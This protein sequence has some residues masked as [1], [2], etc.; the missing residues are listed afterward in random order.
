MCACVVVRRALQSTTVRALVT[1]TQQSGRA[2]ACP[3]SRAATNMAC[4]RTALGRPHT[5]SDANTPG[6]QS[7]NKHQN[8]CVGARLC[9]CVANNRPR[10]LMAA[11]RSPHPHWC[12][13]MA[14]TH[15]RHPR[16]AHRLSERT[17]CECKA[18]QG[19]AHKHWQ[20]AAA[21]QAAVQQRGRGSC[22][23]MIKASRGLR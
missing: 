7:T 20:A 5:S 9:G 11:G 6:S 2:N 19:H 18:R 13:H 12:H 17:A 10:R 14:A 1:A 16:C 3:T 22:V 23:A 15:T 8:T 21:L 4:A